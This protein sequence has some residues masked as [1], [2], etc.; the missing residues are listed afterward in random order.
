MSQ[1][2]VGEIRLVGFDFAPVGWMTCQGQ[3]L[4]IS[5]YEV[6]F[7]LIGTTF[8]GDGQETFNLP[9][10]R[11]RVVIHQG[12]KGQSY[13]LGEQGGVESVALTP[14]EISSHAHVLNAAS[15]GHS[16]SAGPSVIL[17]TPIVGATVYAPLGSNSPTQLSPNSIGATGGNQPHSNLQPFLTLNYIISLFGVFPS[18]S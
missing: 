17:G 2:Y 12:T 10:L 6:L 11:S 5:E 4:A 16:A 8:G 1:P 14:G 9:D 18:Q 7:N 3:L 15:D 13:T